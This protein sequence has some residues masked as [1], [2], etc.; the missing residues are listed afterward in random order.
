MTGAG[1][2]SLGGRAKAF[3]PTSAGLAMRFA[4]LETQG[5]RESIEEL[6]QRYWK[7]VYTFIRVAWKKSNDDAKD[8]TQAFF[9]WLTEREPLRAYAPAKGGFRTF[10]KVLLRRFLGHDTAGL[11]RLKRGGGAVHLSFEDDVASIEEVLPEAQSTDPDRL[12]DQAWLVTVMKAATDRV[13][14]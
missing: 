10:L 6:A 3:P 9:L 14:E 8:L 11:Q 4:G 7:P 5:Y 2:T 1:D 12:F 13:R